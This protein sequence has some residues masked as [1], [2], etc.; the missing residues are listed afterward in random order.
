[1]DTVP[2]QF[3]FPDVPTFGT[4]S[5][6]EVSML[7]EILEESKSCSCFRILGFPGKCRY[8]EIISDYFKSRPFTFVFTQTTGIISTEEPIKID[9]SHLLLF[10]NCTVK[11]TKL[12]IFCRVLN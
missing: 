7:M 6:G 2:I 12:I 4:E 3:E 5:E 8:E 9:P 10:M 1:M 11:V